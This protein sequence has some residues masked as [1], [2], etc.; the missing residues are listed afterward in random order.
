MR[1]K[2]LLRC[3]H[4]RPINKEYL[5]TRHIICRL[6]S[7]SLCCAFSREHRNPK[8]NGSKLITCAIFFWNTL[9]ISHIWLSCFSYLSSQ[10]MEFVTASHS[11]VSNTLFI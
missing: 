8:T 10:N 11:A 2:S 5:S 7:G 6:A 1:V 4:F 9:Y 3:S